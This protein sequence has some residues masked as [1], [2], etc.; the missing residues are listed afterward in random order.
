[1]F[2]WLVKQFKPA[3]PRDALGQR[4]ENVAARYLRNQGYKIIE[5]NFRCEV[6]EVDIIARD[7]R[8]L[9]FAEV[10]TRTYDDPTPE[11]QVN[12]IKRHQLTKAA[13][14]YLSRYGMPQPPARFDVVAIVWPTGRDPQIRHT[15]DAF[16]ATF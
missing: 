8:T 5:R 15:P 16:E 7:G 2:E 14:Y 12:D 1:M 6:G 11:E 4:G 10:K 9:V 3:P 13:K